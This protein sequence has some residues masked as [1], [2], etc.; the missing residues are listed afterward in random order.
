VHISRGDLR[1]LLSPRSG[2]FTAVAGTDAGHRYPEK[3]CELWPPSTVSGNFIKLS[4]RLARWKEFRDFRRT[5]SYNRLARSCSALR[6]HGKR[7]AG[8]VSPCA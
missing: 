8:T 7:Q 1:E 2:G 6:R 4:K 5:W 3:S